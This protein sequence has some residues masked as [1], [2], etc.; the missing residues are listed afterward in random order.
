MAEDAVAEC[1]VV[2]IKDE[3]KGQLPLGF[4]IMKNSRYLLTFKLNVIYL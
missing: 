1:A 4:C 2:G 3:L